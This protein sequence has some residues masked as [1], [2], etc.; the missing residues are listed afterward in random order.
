MQPAKYIFRFACLLALPLAS[1]SHVSADEASS[2]SPAKSAEAIIVPDNV[3]TVLAARC[4]DCHGSDTS[5]GD[6]RFD[7]LS[8]MNFD[9]RLE[10]L[11]RA[12]EQIFFGRMPPADADQ[13][14]DAERELVAGWLSAELKR[15]G[16]SKLEDKLQTPEYGNYVDHDK[17]FSGAY[18]DLKPFTYDR[19]WLISEFIFDAKFNRILNHNATLD[20]DGKRQSVIGSNNRRVN[21]TN[22]FLLP[23]NSG[24]RY[25]ANETLNGGHLL[26]M[27]TNAKEAATYMMYLA[28]RDSRY[29]PA[30]NA[31]MAL[32]DQHNATLASRENFLN[33]HIE[34]VLEGDLPG[35]A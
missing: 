4:L 23:T 32:E 35:Q 3:Q 29:L 20:V 22:P 16:A 24:V 21:L 1:F 31:I 18:K 13:P 33:T 26:T 17:L 5:E 34:H 27:L 19:R 11:N 14:S 2:P 10:L 8:T 15:F 9:A 7:Q 30:I 12:Q 28:G 25:Y 6:V